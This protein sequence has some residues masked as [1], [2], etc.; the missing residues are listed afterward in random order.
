MKRRVERSVERRVERRVWK[1]S[2][3]C[4]SKRVSALCSR[5]VPG[6]RVSIYIRRARSQ[7]R[8][9]VLSRYTHSLREGRARRELGPHCRGG[10]AGGTEGGETREGELSEKGCRPPPYKDP[11][12]ASVAKNGQ[13][14]P[15]DDQVSETLKYEPRDPGGG[16]LMRASLHSRAPKR[17]INLVKRG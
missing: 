8:L 2:C 15:R 9:L 6:R 16:V 3:I 14:G 5:Q 13:S 7:S 4:G 12:T 10:R 17:C 11:H 1:T